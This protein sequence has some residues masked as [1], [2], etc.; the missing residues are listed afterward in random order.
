MPKHPNIVLF[1]PETLRADSVF[2]PQENRA[3]TPHIDAIGDAG[4]R[5]ERCY[6]QYSVCSP[7]RCSMFTGLYPHT[8]GR[9][10][11]GT[12]I[13][14]HEHNLFRDLRDA[15]YETIV[16][17]KNDM[18]FPD[19]ARESFDR[20]GCRTKADPKHAG[21]YDREEGDR[22]FY[23]FLHGR[24][25]DDDGTCH[26]GDWANLQ[27]MLDYLD[28]D[29]DKPFCVLMAG[30]YAHP[31][32]MA[33]EPFY[34]MYDRS[35]MPAPLE[36]DTDRKRRYVRMI[37]EEYGLDQ[38]TDAEWA[39]IRA[40]YFAMVSR[41]DDDLGQIVAKLK[42]RELWDETA[43]L[44][45]SDH[46][47]FCGDYGLVEKWFSACE[48]AI[49][50][51]PLVMRVPG[52]EATGSRQALVEMVDL[53]PTVLEIAGVSDAHY[54]FGKSVL[55]LCDPAATDEHR[56]AAFSEGGHNI[57]EDYIHD[58]ATD[59]GGVYYHKHHLWQV[60]PVVI[61]KAWM[62]RD[63]RFK[64]VYCPDEFDEL[65]DMQVDPGET[66]NLADAP[67]HADTVLRMK[68]MLL[69][70]LSRTTDQIPED[71]RRCGWPEE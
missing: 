42:E 62:V 24:T 58:I 40:V 34:S 25:G 27:D 20:W 1:M 49:L 51:V 18:M 68:G 12:L 28:E 52:M 66:V 67:E 16:I 15:G 35:K 36:T 31:P 13:R 19:A 60:D 38:V 64:F 69:E 4:V 3:I 59:Y 37:H 61:G 43:V 44:C 47:D 11:L 23:S 26:D 57:D 45:F 53:Y 71:E 9:R 63:E 32:Y 48:D 33:P 29:H 41:A 14:E 21:G 55:G 8:A 7:S 22:L 56:P 65:Y 17:G 39:E 54:H 2:G 6:A 70:W 50:R 5:F 46:G 30:S 10:T